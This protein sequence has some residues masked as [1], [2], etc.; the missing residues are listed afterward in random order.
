MLVRKLLTARNV[1]A[2]EHPLLCQK[3]G[4]L[5][6]AGLK[7]VHPDDMETVKANLEAALDPVD[8]RRTVTHPSD[9][10]HSAPLASRFS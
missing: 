10:C 7:L 8:P 4:S 6:L 2:H 1:S 9:S 3:P 5:P